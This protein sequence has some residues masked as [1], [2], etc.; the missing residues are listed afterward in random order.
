MRI[1]AHTLM[2]LKLS[3]GDLVVLKG[4]TPQSSDTLNLLHETIEQVC[5]VNVLVLQ[6]HEGET[7]EVLS[8]ET[9][10]ILL[11]KLLSI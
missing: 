11:E 2:K 10:K 1:T 8:K 3:D 5:H 4:G 9:A 6:L 7:I